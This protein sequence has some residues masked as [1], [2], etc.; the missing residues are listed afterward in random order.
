MP[1]LGWLWQMPHRRSRNPGISAY[2]QCC[3]IAIVWNFF[4]VNNP[5]LLWN[6]PFAL[7]DVCF[8]RLGQSH[9]SFEVWG[10]LCQR[11]WS[12]HQSSKTHILYKFNDISNT[13]F[14][15]STPWNESM[16][17]W[18]TSSTQN[19]I[20]KTNFVLKKQVF[21]TIRLELALCV[22]RNVTI[23]ESVVF[24]VPSSGTVRFLFD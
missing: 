2:L 22:R 3:L 20:C 4:L 23:V 6:S 19:N 11:E 1:R 13:I 5:L 18:L 8:Q 15:P 21:I 12:Q 10:C 7:S 17:N 14:S 16:F 9:K 24:L